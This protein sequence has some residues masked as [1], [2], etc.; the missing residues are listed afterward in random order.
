MP[1]SFILTLFLIVC[2][3]LSSACLSVSVFESFVSES[4]CNEVPGRN[5]LFDCCSKLAKFQGCFKFFLSFQPFLNELNHLNSSNFDDP[6]AGNCFN[7][8]RQ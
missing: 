6:G 2:L 3:S 1:L 5:H 7:S 8:V 4:V